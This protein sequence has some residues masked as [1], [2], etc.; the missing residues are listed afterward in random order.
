MKTPKIRIHW[1]TDSIKSGIIIRETKVFE[2]DEPT[3][4]VMTLATLD[5]H[6]RR[7]AVAAPG[8]CFFQTA[9]KT[10]AVYPHGESSVKTWYIEEPTEQGVGKEYDISY[11]EIDQGIFGQLQLLYR[12]GLVK[13]SILHLLVD[14]KKAMSIAKLHEVVSTKHGQGYMFHVDKYLVRTS[15]NRVTEITMKK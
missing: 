14:L 3:P 10:A 6:L 13:D 8:G 9:Y 7:C 15:Q 2:W 1:V 11:M 12:Q 4:A 5:R